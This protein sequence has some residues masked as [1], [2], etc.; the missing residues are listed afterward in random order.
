MSDIQDDKKV[1][2]LITLLSD[3]AYETLRNILAPA[4]PSEKA[5]DELFQ[6]LQAYFEPPQRVI[7]ERYK[8]GTRNQRDGEPIAAF[9]AELKRLAS[10]CE[11]TCC[12]NYSIRDRLVI[13]MKSAQI[14]KNAFFLR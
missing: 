13:G 6:T 14:K 9:L 12:L 3:S 10:S 11:F 8:F 4:K 2:A 5:Y 1:S 7:A